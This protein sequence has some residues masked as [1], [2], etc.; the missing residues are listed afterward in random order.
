MVGGF[1]Q[2]QQVGRCSS[3][4]GC[5]S[6]RARSRRRT[7]PPAVVVDCLSKPTA[8]GGRGASGCDCSLS[9]GRSR[10]MMSSARLVRV[11]RLD[12]VLVEPADL[13]CVGSRCQSVQSAPE[14]QR[15]CH[16]LGEGGLA[17]A[18][19]AQQADPVVDVEAQVE[20]A[21]A[22]VPRRRSRPPHPPGAAAAAFSGRAR[23]T[24]AA[25]GDTSRSTDMVAAIG[26]IFSSRFMRRLRLCRLRG[27]GA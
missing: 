10:R 11:H 24:A 19:H 1:V 18:V 25:N 7:S 2:D 15:F 16:H 8:P 26:S 9:C 22:P 20:A 17:G 12:L 27:L 4:P 14:A 5:S 3:P 13:A 6:S 23:E 21:T